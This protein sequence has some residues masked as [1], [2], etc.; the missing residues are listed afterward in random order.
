MNNI[1]FTVDKFNHIIKPRDLLISDYPHK[2]NYL[3]LIKNIIGNSRLIVSS[4][5]NIFLIDTLPNT[6][7]VRK[8]SKFVGSYEDEEYILYDDDIAG[9]ILISEDCINTIHTIVIEKINYRNEKGLFVPKYSLREIM[10][11]ELSNFVMYNVQEMFPE[12]TLILYEKCEK[13]ERQYINLLE[14]I[15]E[16]G[17]KR[18]GRNGV[19]YSL[20]CKHLKFD[21]RNG[22]PLITTK[23]MFIRGIIEELLFFLRGDT[24]TTILD[25]KKINIWKGNT[26]SDFL[27]QKGLPYAPG[28][29]GPMYG[30]QW[31]HFGMK[32]EVDSKGVPI[33]KNGGVDQLANVI[34]LLKTDPTSRRI[35]LTD[36]NPAQAEEGVLYPCHS[37]V[38]QFYVID[39]FL[40]IFCYNRSQD[41]LLGVPFNIASTALLHMIVAKLSDLTPRYFNL[42]MGDAHIYDVH[43]DAVKEQISRVPY[44]PPKMKIN[45]EL[46][47]LDDIKELKFEDFELVEYMSHPS[48]KA[49]MVA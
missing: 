7:G 16:N 30:Y 46:K 31:R 34:N 21:L 17:D 19:T 45:K 39:G 47:T 25:E 15:L 24:D 18:K 11:Y 23:K 40:D 6:F 5:T 36:Y 14:D 9:S 8:Y 22:F 13:G 2:D 27:S 43:K 3:S 1:I 48:I 20:F 32:Y 12:I 49:M 35:L 44:R 26:N 29:M 38:I 42:S 37:I 28:V 33:D 4:E 41:T 10:L